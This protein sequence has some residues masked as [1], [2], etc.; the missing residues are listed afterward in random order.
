MKLDPSNDREFYSRPRFMNHVDDAFLSQLTELY[1][2]LLPPGGRVLELGCSHVSHLP[3]E[4]DYD[5]TGTGLNAE[6]L[7]RNPRLSSFAV[8]NLNEEPSDWPY[9]SAAYDAVVCC[10]SVQYYQQPERV[11]SEICRC[12]KPGGVVIISFSNRL[13]SSKAIAAW[14][15]GTGYSR[16][17]LV[18]SYINAIAGF[19]T[20]AVVTGLEKQR[21][22]S[23]LGRL[24]QLF[25]RASSD[26]FYAVIARRSTDEPL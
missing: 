6:E 3:P 15:D 19:A 8:R 10:V 12:L 18:K 24:S 22:N 2:R 13:F 16:T 14:R 23:L 25:A 17:Q 21:D 11:F 4:V 5:V 20:P 1:R 9:P 7:A 26:P